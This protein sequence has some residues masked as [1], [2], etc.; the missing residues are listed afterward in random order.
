MLD[1]RH[2]CRF[3]CVHGSVL[4]WI[5]AGRAELHAIQEYVPGRTPLSQATSDWDRIRFQPLPCETEIVNL[6]LEGAK[7]R[8][9]GSSGKHNPTTRAKSVCQPI[10]RMA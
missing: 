2:G 10:R 5:E 8:G 4:C 3:D 6:R 7:H 9:M 1:G